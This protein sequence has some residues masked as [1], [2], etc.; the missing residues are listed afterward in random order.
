LFVLTGEQR[1][2][3]RQLGKD[4]S[5]TP[6]VDADRVTNA[7]DDFGGSVEPGLDVGVHSFVFKAG[8]PEIDDLDAIDGVK[9]VD[10]F[11]MILARVGG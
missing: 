3:C 5:K 9:E 2:A 6:H 7:K 10:A 11:E 8:G 4:A 1:V